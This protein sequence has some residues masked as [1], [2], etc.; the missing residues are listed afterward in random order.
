MS[1]PVRRCSNGASVTK[2]AREKRTVCVEHACQFVSRRIAFAAAIVESPPA[3]QGQ[4][5]GVSFAKF[6]GTCAFVVRLV[7]PHGLFF[8]IKRKGRG[9]GCTTSGSRTL[10]LLHA[11]EDNAGRHTSGAMSTNTRT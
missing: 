5:L 1:N 4:H 2:C 6:A 9:C 3:R 8:G 7:E 11:V 10:P